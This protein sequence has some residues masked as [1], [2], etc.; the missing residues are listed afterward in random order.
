MEYENRLATEGEVLVVHRFRSGS[1]GLASPD[2]CCKAQSNSVRPKT[3]WSIVKEFFQGIEAKSV[4]AVCIPPGARL[5]L[6]GVPEPVQKSLAV[7]PDEE[8]AF[9]QISATAHSYRDAVRFRTGHTLRL[10]DLREGQLVE[11][12]DLGYGSPEEPGVSELADHLPV[13]AADFRR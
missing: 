5:I 4:P 1:L 6:H 8:V 10:Q 3:F 11:V 7:G 13:A 9:M 12:V 2:D